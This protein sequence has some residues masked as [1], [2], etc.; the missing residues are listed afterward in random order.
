MQC[1]ACRIN[2]VAVTNTDDDPTQPYQLC[3]ECN[4]RLVGFA[5]RP[6]EWFNLA[7]KH[8][9]N[10]YLLH[11]D[12][13]DDDGTAYQPEIPVDD[14]SLLP[15]PKLSDI[16]RDLPRLLDMAITQWF[17]A[18]D[19]VD[20]FSDHDAKAVLDALMVRT[21]SSQN[22]WVESTCLQIC[23][24]SLGPIAAEWVRSRYGQS[25][26]LLYWWVAAAAACLPS[27]DAWDSATK[28]I[29]Q[30]QNVREDAQSLGWFRDDRTLD[31]IEEQLP[32]LELP[33]T[34][35]WGRLA[36]ISRLTWSRTES[37]LALGRP[38]SLVALDAMVSCYHYDTMNLKRIQPKLT[39]EVAESY[40]SE[41]LDRYLASDD[42]PR[43]SLAIAKVKSNLA[44]IVGNGP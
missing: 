22:A 34:Q 29:A 10:K 15:A 20:A 28:A 21:D 39:A 1:E 36:A 23:A 32:I 26:D 30:S 3:A 24:R 37:W 17:L 13:Y 6:L 19:V 33:V 42:V 31:W 18:D 40:I 12:F 41:A 11:D 5:L 4:S 44:N 16:D 2:Q 27:D 7:A 9:P 38:L 25:P 8:G 14:A 35:D 43:V